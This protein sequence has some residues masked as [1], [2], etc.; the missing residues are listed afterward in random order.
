M[1]RHPNFRF[2]FYATF[3]DVFVPDTSSAD[4]RGVTILDL[5]LMV[6][7]G[8]IELNER[9]RI[10]DAELSEGYADLF[11]QLQ[12]CW[13]TSVLLSLP[14]PGYTPD[15]GGTYRVLFHL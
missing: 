1:N 6:V 7:L 3:T 10:L 5:Q 11:L 14:N 13:D 4:N 15:S 9:Y 8:A 2:L 12:T